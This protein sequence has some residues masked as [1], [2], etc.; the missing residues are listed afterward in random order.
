MIP[1][2]F[3]QFTHACY[4][5]DK[6]GDERGEGPQ[7]DKA[8]ALTYINYEGEGERKDESKGEGMASARPRVRVG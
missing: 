5:S 3:P 2:I 4:L 8:P 7:D 1:A 6:R